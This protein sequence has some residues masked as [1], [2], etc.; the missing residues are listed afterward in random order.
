MSSHLNEGIL[1]ALVIAGEPTVRD[2]VTAALRDEGWTVVQ[3]PS[4]EDALRADA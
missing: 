1:H 2:F 3:S 4:A